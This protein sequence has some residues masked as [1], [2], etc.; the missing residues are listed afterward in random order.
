MAELTTLSL[1]EASEELRK[2]RVSAREL[3]EATLARIEQTEPVV[4]AFVQILPERARRQA[5]HADIHHRALWR[6]ADL[7]LVRHALRRAD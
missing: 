1:L 3:T 7:F 6:P 4:H 2:R 5:A